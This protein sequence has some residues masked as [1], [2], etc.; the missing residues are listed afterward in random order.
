MPLDI[1]DMTTTV[2]GQEVPVMFIKRWPA[3]VKLKGIR[4]VSKS[5]K[6]LEMD[7]FY[8]IAPDTLEIMRESHLVWYA[9][10]YRQAPE[11][12]RLQVITPLESML[13]E[14]A[15]HIVATNPPEYGADAQQAL[16][17]HLYAMRILETQIKALETQIEDKR[18]TLT[19]MQAIHALHMRQQS[20]KEGADE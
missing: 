15:K 1:Y 11:K 3:H 8:D 10:N 7:S 19:Y 16:K 4:S 12:V 9:S 6:M 18:R 2:N 14:T 17:H 13:R 5:G 20:P